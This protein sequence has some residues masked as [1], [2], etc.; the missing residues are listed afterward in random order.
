MTQFYSL[1]YKTEWFMKYNYVLSIA[2]DS[3]MAMAVL[4]VTVI[5]ANSR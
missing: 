2:M 5:E 4:S 1:K 3:G